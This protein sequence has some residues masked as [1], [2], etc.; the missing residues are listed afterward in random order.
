MSHYCQILIT[1]YNYVLN[2]EPAV[3]IIIHQVLNIYLICITNTLS[4]DS[5]KFSLVLFVHS[6]N[7]IFEKGDLKFCPNFGSEWIDQLKVLLISLAFFC[8]RFIESK[9]KEEET[10]NMKFSVQY[11][12]ICTA[13]RHIYCRVLINLSAVLVFAWE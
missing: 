10:Q 13:L 5:T 8:T 2:D 11:R 9:E 6:L 3:I 4:L 1:F 12:H 7:Y